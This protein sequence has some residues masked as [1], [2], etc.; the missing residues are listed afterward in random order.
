MTGTF[1]PPGYIPTQSALPGYSLSR[2]G[3]SIKPVTFKIT[4]MEFI[5]VYKEAKV[6]YNVSE[7]GKWVD[8]SIFL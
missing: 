3:C 8:F 4:T 7:S 2:F 1:L 5:N 6:S